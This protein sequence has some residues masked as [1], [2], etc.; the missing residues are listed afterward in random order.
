MAAILEDDISKWIFLNG[1]QISLKFVPRSPIDNTPALVQ[2]IT[3]RRTG[4]KPLPEPK[5]TQF[6]DALMRY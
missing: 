6:I 4:H 5:M 1:I 3:W 2:V